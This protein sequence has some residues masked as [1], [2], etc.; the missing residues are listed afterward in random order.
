MFGRSQIPPKSV[1]KHMAAKGVCCTRLQR[2][3]LVM[4]M[5]WRLSDTMTQRTCA[6][7]EGNIKNGRAGRY[8]RKVGFGNQT[9]QDAESV[10]NP[11]HDKQEKKPDN[12]RE[13]ANCNEQD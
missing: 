3:N 2:L 6:Q 4:S 1:Q 11:K 7:N 9:G 12:D 5:I 13:E 10:G 8:G